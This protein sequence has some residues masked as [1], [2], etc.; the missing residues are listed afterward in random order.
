M[1]FLLAA[2]CVG[3]L[4]VIFAIQGEFEAFGGGMVV[5]VCLAVC[6]ILRKRGKNRKLETRTNPVSSESVNNSPA[7]S[8][9]VQPVALHTAQ[10]GTE[11]EQEQPFSGLVLDSKTLSSLNDQA[12]FEYSKQYLAYSKSIGEK[13]DPQKFDEVSQQ[14][15]RIRKE[16]SRREQ[17]LPYKTENHHVAGTSHYQ[18]ELESLGEENPAY[19]YSKEEL[20]EEGYEDEKVYYYDFSPNTVELVEEPENAYDP[21]AIKVIVDG[22]HIGYIKRGSC[23]HVKQLLH[24]GK[25]TK[26]SAEIRGGKYK[27]LYC[28]YDDEKG[29]DVYQLECEQSDYYATV[30]IQYTAQ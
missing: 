15:E 29:K 14:L 13:E 9:S 11:S 1:G 5:V 20:V 16:I 3:V 19:E 26:I 27:F 24:S 22:V 8:P 25:I 28:E 4:S 12:F 21:N 23:A 2:I 17:P 10:Q 7:Q 6:W 18:R 30:I